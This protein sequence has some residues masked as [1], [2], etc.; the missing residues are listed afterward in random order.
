MCF[1]VNYPRITGHGGARHEGAG[2][3]G[4]CAFKRSNHNF[5]SGLVRLKFL[6]NKQS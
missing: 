5:N 4:D 3:G 1:K 2:E 6:A